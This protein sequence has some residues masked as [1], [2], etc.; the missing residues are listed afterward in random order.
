MFSSRRSNTQGY[1][2]DITA[3]IMRISRHYD[4]EGYKQLNIRGARG[5][6][7]KNIINLPGLQIS[8]PWLGNHY[9]LLFLQTTPPFQTS[10]AFSN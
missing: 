10:K 1:P 5:V 2:I 9:S 3:K 6:K 8:D 7:N 4:Q